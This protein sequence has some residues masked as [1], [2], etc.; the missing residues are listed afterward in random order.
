MVGQFFRNFPVCA[1]AIAHIFYDKFYKFCGAGG[2]IFEGF[3]FFA[4]SH[5]FAP[6]G[7]RR[8][9]AH[10]TDSQSIDLGRF[11]STAEDEFEASM[12]AA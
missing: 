3:V 5:T 11:E 7:R 9:K 4:F 8:A 6:S 1:S 10:P 12:Q 2:E